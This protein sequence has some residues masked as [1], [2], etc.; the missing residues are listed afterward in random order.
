MINTTYI[1]INKFYPERVKKAYIA[2]ANELYRKYGYSLAQI[3]R[4]IKV[5][6]QTLIKW[7][8]KRIYGRLN[9]NLL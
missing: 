8:E 3:A 5:T 9:K 2:T 7:H 4:I 1:G 6:R